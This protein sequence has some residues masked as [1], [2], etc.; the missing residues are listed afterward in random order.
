[1]QVI[2]SVEARQELEEAEQYYDRQLPG[3]GG[4]FHVEVKSA[5][6]L[7]RAWPLSCPIELDAIRRLNLSRFPYKLLYSVESDHIYIVALSH[8]HQAPNYWV[9]RTL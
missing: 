2:F 3:L 9:D 8:Q 5:L 6:Q 4:R 7:V 1:M